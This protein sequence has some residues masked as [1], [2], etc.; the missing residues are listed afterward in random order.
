MLTATTPSTPL[1]S[2]N[3]ALLFPVLSQRR[4][5]MPRPLR[6]WLGERQQVDEAGSRSPVCGRM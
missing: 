4:E 6:D 2:A 5:A 3:A 1:T